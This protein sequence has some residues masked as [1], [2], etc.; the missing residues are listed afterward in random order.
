MVHGGATMEAIRLKVHV[1]DDG[2]LRLELPI[3]SANVD[4]DVT[5]TVPMTM[6]RAEW[7]A[8]LE[9]TAGSLAG[10]LIEHGSQGEYEVR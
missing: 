7:L 4:C 3:G 5:I 8:F 6:S 9:E 2:I 10:N 1:S